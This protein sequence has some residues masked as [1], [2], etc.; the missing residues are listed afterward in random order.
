MA[1]MEMVLHLEKMRLHS[2]QVYSF[3]LGKLAKILIMSAF[4]RSPFLAL[5][6]N[7]LDIFLLVFIS[8]LCTAKVRS[9]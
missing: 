7:S 1:R 3:C 5:L 2:F 8:I 9:V 4:F 6:V